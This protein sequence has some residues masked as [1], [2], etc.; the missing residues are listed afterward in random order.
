MIDSVFGRHCIHQPPR[1]ATLQQAVTR[2]HHTETCIV[3]PR[4]PAGSL[5]SPR[6]LPMQRP[7]Y[8]TH[9][10]QITS[11]TQ[12]LSTRSIVIFRSILFLL[13]THTCHSWHHGLHKAGGLP[14]QISRHTARRRRRRVGG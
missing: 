10:T 13:P 1:C 11:A 14:F 6:Q 3:L 7:T 12:Q 4:R 5:A 2:T 8:V 9:I